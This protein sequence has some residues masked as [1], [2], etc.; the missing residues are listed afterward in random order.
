MPSGTQRVLIWRPE[1][2]THPSLR[3]NVRQGLDPS[4]LRAREPI[5]IVHSDE[6]LQLS[7]EGSPKL[8]GEPLAK[9][10]GL[11]AH[12]TRAS[13][14]PAWKR[15][16]TSVNK[17]TDAWQFQRYRVRSSYKTCGPRAPFECSRSPQPAE[18]TSHN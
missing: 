17:T 2:G 12:L 10:S 14:A 6:M 16:P 3:S 9:S 18:A 8:R 11:R 1:C 15:C 4:T 7:S 13:T 5:H